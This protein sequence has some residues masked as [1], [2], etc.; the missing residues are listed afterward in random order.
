M[1]E[2]INLNLILLRLWRWWTTLDCEMPSSPDT[3]LVLLTRFASM[4]W[5]TALESSFMSILPD[6]CN[7][8]KVYWTIKSMYCDQLRIHLLNNKC[9]WLLPWCHGRFKHLKRGC[10]PGVMM[11]AMDS[12]IV[13]SKF[14]LQSCYYD[15]FRTNTFGERYE[16]PYPPSYGLNSITAVLLEGRL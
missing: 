8:G 4:A 12:R 15:H 7:L 1:W 16:P 11:K 2:L 6:S 10:P 14:E 5:S 3:L 9:F 13:G